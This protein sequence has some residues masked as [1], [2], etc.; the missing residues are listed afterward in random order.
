MKTVVDAVNYLKGVWNE[1]AY[2]VAIHS[3]NS[4]FCLL[5]PPVSGAGFEH[6]C[7]ELEFNAAVK[8]MSSGEW[9]YKNYDKP[10]TVTVDGMV[11]EIGKLYEFSDD[12]SNW[13][14]DS[15]K[16]RY[17]AGDEFKFA[18]LISYWAMCRECKLEFGAIT[19]A[20]VELVDGEVYH[21]ELNCDLWVGF[22]RKSRDSF[23]T[24]LAGGN[25]ICAS[26]QAKQV[27]RLIPEVK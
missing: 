3:H 20:P 16:C 23:F 9:C 1:R 8:Q 13:F 27:S 6:V 7:N 18:S 24:Q 17:A 10:E 14:Q 2:C 21:F 12:G 11:Y 19:P 22:Y 26:S 25:K 4:E 5:K 15:L